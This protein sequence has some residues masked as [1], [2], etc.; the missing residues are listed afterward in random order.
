[1]THPRHSG[2]TTKALSVVRAYCLEY[3][4]RFAVIRLSQQPVDLHS[5]KMP[6]QVP[7]H[8]GALL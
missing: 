3:P 4:Q 5:S 2:K 1:M 7:R 8:L 6:W